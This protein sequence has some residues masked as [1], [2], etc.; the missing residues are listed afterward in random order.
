[1]GQRLSLDIH[2]P[3]ILHHSF[4]TVEIRRLQAGITAYHQSTC[5]LIALTLRIQG[6]LQKWIICK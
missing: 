6:I 1:M 2:F 3:Q 4:D 5:C